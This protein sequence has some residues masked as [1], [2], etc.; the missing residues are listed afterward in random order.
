M[1]EILEPVYL[2][3][4]APDP[5]RTHPHRLAA[6]FMI[7][8]MGAYYRKEDPIKLQRLFVYRALGRASFCLEGRN[9]RKVII[10]R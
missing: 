9:R 3:S 8:A 7:I 5:T 4:N 6:F 10:R 1:Q 2:C